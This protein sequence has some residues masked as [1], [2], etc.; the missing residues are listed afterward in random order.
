MEVKHQDWDNP[1]CSVFKEMHAEKKGGKMC[2]QCKGRLW[3]GVSSCPLLEKVRIQQPIALKLSKNV[4]GPSPP[5]AFVGWNNYPFVSIGPLVSVAEGGNAAIYDSPDKWYGLGF[6]DIISFRSRLA[7]GRSKQHVKEKTRLLGD[8]QDA[9]MSRNTVDMEVE[10]DR[11]PR[12]AMSFS[13]ISQP[14]GPSANVKK[15]ELAENPK[16]PRKI[17][18]AVEEDVRVR[19]ILP[20]LVTSGFDYYY[21]QKLLSAGLLGKQDDKKIVPTRWGI[22]ATDR[23]MGDYYI[24]Q[25][26]ECDAVGEIRVYTNEYL[27]NH[28]EILLLPGKW[29]FEQFE[30]WSPKTIWTQ[31]EDDA[32]IAHEYEPFEGRS[33]YAVT[34]GG[35]YYAG[36]FACAEGLAKMRKQARVVVFREIYEGYQMPVGVWELRENVRNAFRNIPER[37]DTLKSALASIQARLRNGMASYLD[38]SIVMRQKKL[39]DF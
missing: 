4:F 5:N 30:S 12:Y 19:E 3:C 32:S 22:T 36:R 38:K 37:H 7:I 18:S 14:M 8:L 23:M 1:R 2:V 39:G 33:D 27:F 21:L 34:E 6:E 25:V 26:K 16:I 13:P 35:G 20:E 15:M 10:F 29:E 9:V 28:F 17:Y 31:S 24:K 11:V